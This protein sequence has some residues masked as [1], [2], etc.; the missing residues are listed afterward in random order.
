VVSAL[1]ESLAQVLDIVGVEAAALIDLGSGMVVA[2]ADGVGASLPGAGLSAAAA[3][4]AYEARSA[5]QAHRRGEDLEEI[6]LTTA[7]RLHLTK[8]LEY[9]RGEGLLLYLDVDLAQTNVTLATWQI[10]Q[11]APG[12]LAG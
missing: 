2:P 10:C 9:R 8:V 1:N 7:S 5:I 3:S 12:L 11:L 6:A 4:M